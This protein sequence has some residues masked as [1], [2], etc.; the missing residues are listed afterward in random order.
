MVRITHLEVAHYIQAC[1]LFEVLGAKGLRKLQ[2]HV[3]RTRLALMPCSGLSLSQDRVWHE[4]GRGMTLPS[5]QSASVVT[6]LNTSLSMCENRA[7]GLW[8]VSAN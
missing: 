2:V 5:V 1:A 8:T 6:N 3:S 4:R 7:Y